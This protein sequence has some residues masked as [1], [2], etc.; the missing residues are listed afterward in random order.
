MIP[1]NQMHKAVSDEDLLPEVILAVE[2][3]FCALEIVIDPGFKAQAVNQIFL[4]EVA[5]RAATQTAPSSFDIADYHDLL[6]F[7]KLAFDSGLE[8]MKRRLE[9]LGVIFDRN[10]EPKLRG[11]D[12]Q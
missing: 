1:E 5:K 12:E 11:R 10:Y 6:S 4:A 2:D 8:R 3:Y 7:A 9:P